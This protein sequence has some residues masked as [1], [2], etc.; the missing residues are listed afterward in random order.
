MDGSGS[1]NQHQSTTVR[2]T[3]FRSAQALA[4]A[5]RHCAGLAGRRCALR[6]ETDVS[7]SSARAVCST[8][9]MPLPPAMKPILSNLVSLPGGE[10]KRGVRRRATGEKGGKEEGA[11]VRGGGGEADHLCDDGGKRGLIR[12][13]RVPS[14]VCVNVWNPAGFSAR[15]QRGPAV[16]KMY[17]PSGPLTEMVSPSAILSRNWVSLPPSGKRGWTLAK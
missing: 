14:G 11:G 2:A 16:L 13:S 9:V 15:V 7:S 6:T 17:S 3:R 5:G 12:S 1:A 8:G 10:H 4:R